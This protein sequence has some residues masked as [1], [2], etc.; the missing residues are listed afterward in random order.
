MQILSQSFHRFL[1]DARFMAL[2]RPQISK[3][4]KFRDYLG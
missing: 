2:G 3:F 4:H 1:D